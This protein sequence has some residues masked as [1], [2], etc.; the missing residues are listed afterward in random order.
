MIE[1]GLTCLLSRLGSGFGYN[2]VK[3][4]CQVRLTVHKTYAT[5]WTCLV[6]LSVQ[7]EALADVPDR[8]LPKSTRGQ[9]LILGG[10]F[11][12][13][14]S[15][16]QM[17]LLWI[18]VSLFLVMPIAGILLGKPE[19]LPWLGFTVGIF[20][21]RNHLSGGRSRASFLTA[22]LRFRIFTALAHL[23]ISFANLMAVPFKLPLVFLFVFWYKNIWLCHY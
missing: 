15:R 13:Y 6:Q 4:W 23:P 9:Y 16:F 21:S 22:S 19:S 3:G 5:Q 17:D 11:S 8:R 1:L 7:A 18:F 20:R 2:A 14:V 10:P 12:E